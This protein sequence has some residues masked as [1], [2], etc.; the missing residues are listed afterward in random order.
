ML[1]SYKWTG[2]DEIEPLNVHLLRAP[3]DAAN[4][5]NLS[6]RAPKTSKYRVFFNWCPPKKLK[7]GKPRLGVSRTIYVDVDSPNLGSR[8][9]NFLGGHQLKKTPCMI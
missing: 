3:L 7:Y 8:H 2:L 1:K 9:F 6:H 5:P 4:N